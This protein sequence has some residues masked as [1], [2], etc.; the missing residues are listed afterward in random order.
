MVTSA[1]VVDFRAR[2]GLGQIDPPPPR[3]LR[4]DAVHQREIAKMYRGD[5]KLVTFK[6][7]HR[8]HIAAKA[9]GGA[10]TIYRV[11]EKYRVGDKEYCFKVL[12]APWVT[13]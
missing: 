4:R 6:K 2:A 1:R 13:P 3:A 5:W 12:D 7:A 8:L 9:M 11:D 10:A